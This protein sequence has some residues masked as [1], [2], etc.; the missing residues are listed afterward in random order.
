MLR[1]I[2]KENKA[3]N[4]EKDNI[5]QNLI[6]QSLRLVPQNDEMM[7]TVTENLGTA[8]NVLEQISAHHTES[9]NIREKMRTLYNKTSKTVYQFQQDIKCC[10]INKTKEVDQRIND[11]CNK[12]QK[13]AQNTM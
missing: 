9:K 6:Q 8:Q 4:D 11:I 12:V 5:I 7:Q 10:T 2:Q 1:N 13:K 3:L